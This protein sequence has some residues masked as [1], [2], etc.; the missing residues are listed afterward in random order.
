MRFP[1]AKT[2]IVQL[3]TVQKLQRRREFACMGKAALKSLVNH[4]CTCA[5]RNP[6]P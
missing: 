2:I 4:I 1:T 6:D 5:R 3:H